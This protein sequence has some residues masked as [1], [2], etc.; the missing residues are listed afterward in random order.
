[1]H[2]SEKVDK[3]C[4]LFVGSVLSLKACLVIG[5]GTYREIG[6]AFEG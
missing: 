1:M 6:A 3:V 5:I 2:E 4:F